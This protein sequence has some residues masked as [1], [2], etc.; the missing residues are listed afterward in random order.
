MEDANGGLSV[1]E[2]SVPSVGQKRKTTGSYE[3]WRMG[4]SWQKV[5][6]NNMVVPRFVGGFQ[7]FKI[8]DNGRCDE[9]IG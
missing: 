3:G 9:N 1:P 2:G 5:T 4:G 6:G 8:K 7:Y